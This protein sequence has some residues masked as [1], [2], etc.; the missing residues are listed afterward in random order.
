MSE[1]LYERREW[2]EAQVQLARK[3]LEVAMMS[4]EA[5]DTLIAE[6]MERIYQ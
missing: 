4:L 5:V 2:W 6:D 1:I 3:A